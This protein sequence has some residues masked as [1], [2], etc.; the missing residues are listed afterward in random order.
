MREK[1]VGLSATSPWIKN[2]STTHS[3]LSSSALRETGD[4]QYAKLKDFIDPRPP[5]APTTPPP[6]TEDKKTPARKARNAAHQL[7]DIGFSPALGKDRTIAL[8]ETASKRLDAASLAAAIPLLQRYGCE[9]LYLSHCPKLNSIEALKGLRSLTYLRLE[10]CASLRS[11]DPLKDLPTLA[12]LEVS[13]CNALQNL[14]GLGGLKSLT[15][16]NLSRI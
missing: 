1:R 14:D 3:Y 9:E 13:S 4:F 12:N 6:P 10:A 8:T 5:Q 16:L 2:H 7:R 11:L 15:A